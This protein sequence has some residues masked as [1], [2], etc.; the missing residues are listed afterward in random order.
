MP[1]L[2]LQKAGLAPTGILSNAAKSLGFASVAALLEMNPDAAQVM[3]AVKESK[4]HQVCHLH[5]T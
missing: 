3:Q 2:H 4:A 5:L 1:C